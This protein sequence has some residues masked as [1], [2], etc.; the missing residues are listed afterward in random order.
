M[1][2]TFSLILAIAMI[3][4]LALSVSAEDTFVFKH[5]FDLDYPPYSYIN[6]NG[7]M[8]GFDVE[9]A[10]AVCDYYGWQYEAVP[11][12]WDAKDLE[13]NAGSCDCIWSGFTINGREDDYLWS[14]PYSDNTQMI[15]VKKGSGI[16]T[17]AD[18]A[19]KVVG[20]QTSTSAYDLLNDEEGQAELCKTFKS[21]EVYETYTIAFNDLKAGAVDALAIDVTSGNFLMSG[22]TDYEFLSEELGSE[23]YGIGFRKDDTELCEKVNAALMAL[24]ED[25]TYDKIGQKYPEI[26][27]Y[28]SLGK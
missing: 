28:L 9:M 15:M 23:Q 27:D 14:I 12:N 18:L 3:A 1:K 8:G 25:G 17:L 5:G 2:K 6:D 7:E 13:L 22:Q 4:V 20:V 11:F 26:Y 21:L 16:E 24:V 19:G 10:Q